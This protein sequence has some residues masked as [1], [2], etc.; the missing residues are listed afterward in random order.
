M[1]ARK[2]PSAERTG[3]APR[4]GR[5]PRSAANRT[6]ANGQLD[7]ER[8]L[9]ELSLLQEFAQLATRARDW[10]D[11]MRTLVDRTTLAIG[12]EVCSFYLLERDGSTLTLAATNGLDKEHVGLLPL[13]G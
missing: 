4:R 10:D 8:K 13:L 2:S 5:T 12:V 7:T 9:R 3:P 11:L 1:S 6:A